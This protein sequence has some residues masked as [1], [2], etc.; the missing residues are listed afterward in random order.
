MI[1]VTCALII[2]HNEKILVA[3]RSLAMR[4][5][6]KWE[7]PGGKV[8]PGENPEECLLREIAEELDVVVEI[9]KPML[10]CEHND[11]KQAIRLIPFVCIIKRGEIRLAEHAA[12]VWLK[13][14][15]LQSLD[16]A[17]ADIPVVNQ[18]LEGLSPH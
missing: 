3:Q 6:L 14:A 10:P 17:A 5:P 16:W 13:A 7:F 15:E 9:I 18:F 4:L 11:G 8:E 12:F 2:G 1:D